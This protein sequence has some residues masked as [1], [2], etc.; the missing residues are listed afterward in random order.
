MDKNGNGYLDVDDF[1]WGFIDYGFQISKEDAESFTK[2]F[3]KNNDN[4]VSY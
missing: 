3:D 1:R 2:H 4:L